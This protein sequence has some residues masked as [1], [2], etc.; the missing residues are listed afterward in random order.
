MHEA[1]YAGTTYQQSTTTPAES[2]EKPSRR[3]NTVYKKA[4]GAPKRFKSSYVHFFTNFVEKKKR[5]VGPDGLVSLFVIVHIILF[6]TYLKYTQHDVNGLFCNIITA[7]KVR[8]I[9][10]INRMLKGME[11]PPTK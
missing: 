6:P 2:S 9:S 8:H 10:S 1:F 11:G 5:Q 7:S 4:P 3:L